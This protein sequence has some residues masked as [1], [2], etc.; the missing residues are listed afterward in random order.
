MKPVQH[1]IDEI[2]SQPTLYL[3]GEA[4]TEHVKVTPMSVGGNETRGGDITINMEFPN[5][6]T[7]PADPQQL[8]KQYETLFRLILNDLQAVQ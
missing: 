6:Y 5:V 8:R 2:I 7:L 4:G 1:G 3:A